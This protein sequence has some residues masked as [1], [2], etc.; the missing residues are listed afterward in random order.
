MDGSCFPMKRLIAVGLFLF[1]P[2]QTWCAAPPL[3][4]C[5]EGGFTS[6]PGSL[7]SFTPNVAVGNLVVC[8]TVIQGTTTITGDQDGG[9][10]QTWTHYTTLNGT[11]NET[12]ISWTVVAGSGFGSCG[13]TWA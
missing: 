4:K 10:A 13:P 3:H 6:Q 5:A 2:Y 11:S 1:I 7:C 9:T 8:V 12:I